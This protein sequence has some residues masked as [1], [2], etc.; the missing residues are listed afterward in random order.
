MPAIESPAVVIKY[1]LRVP[2]YR[3]LRS[4]DDVY[5]LFTLFDFKCVFN[6]HKS[7]ICLCLRTIACH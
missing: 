1:F 4:L 5:Q 2:G 3:T 7:D 6:C